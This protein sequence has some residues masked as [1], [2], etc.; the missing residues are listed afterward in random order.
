MPFLLRTGKRMTARRTE[1]VIHFR[2]APF[3]L[4]PEVPRGRDSSDRITLSVAP[5]QAIEIRF[6]VKRPGPEMAL[7]PAATRFEFHDA[8]EERPNVGYEALL[9]DA[10]IGDA[11]LF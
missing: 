11:T 7:G 8:F 9:Y 5:E 10:M 4:F 3:A 2:A 1:V 6:D